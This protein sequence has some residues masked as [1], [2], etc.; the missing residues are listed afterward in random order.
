MEHI[1]FLL[2]M[3]SMERKSSASCPSGRRVAECATS[4]GAKNSA[5]FGTLLFLLTFILLFG[6]SFNSLYSPHYFLAFVV[7]SPFIIM[8]MLSLSEK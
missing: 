6:L 4:F 3:R 8:E 7:L 1:Y 5:D 2:G